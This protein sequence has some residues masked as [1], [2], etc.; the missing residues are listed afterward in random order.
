MTNRVNYGKLRE[1]LE[2]PDLI[3]VQVDSFKDFLQLN[4]APDKRHRKGL[5]EI[6]KE[7]FPIESFDQ[8]INVDFVGYRFGESKFDPIDCVKDGESYAMPLYA[9]LAL[10]IKGRKI[11]EEVFFGDF[12]MMTDRGTFI[13]NGAERVIVSQLHRSPGI[14]FEKMRHSSGRGIYSYRI[15]PD[16]GSWLEVQFDINDLIF[17]YLDKRRR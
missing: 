9:T 16:R 6:F 5:Q 13:I 12:P 3:G 1:V 14:C 15:I 11:E 17:I 8:Q 7:V 4:V 10:N 2:I